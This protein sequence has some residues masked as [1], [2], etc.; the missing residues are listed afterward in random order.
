MRRLDRADRFNIFAID[1]VHSLG[2]A[3]KH[4]DEKK[5]K[6]KKIAISIKIEHDLYNTHQVHWTQ[7]TIHDNNNRQDVNMSS[8]ARQP[9]GSEPAVRHRPQETGFA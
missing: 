1:P 4:N 3:I 2:G 9:V 5:K 8:E 7:A 6:K